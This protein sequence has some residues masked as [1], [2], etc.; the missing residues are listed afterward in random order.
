MGESST[1]GVGGDLADEDTWPWR[2]ADLLKKDL[3]GKKLEFINAALGGYSTFESFGRLWS[4][5]RFFSPDIIVVA[6]GWNEMYYFNKVDDITSWRTLPD[7]SWGFSRTMKIA[8]YKPLWIDQLFRNSQILTKIR[9]RLSKPI[10]GEAGV[11]KPLQNSYDRRGLEIFRTNLRLIKATASILGAKLFVIKQATLVVPNL[12]KEYRGWC[13][14]EYH[15]FDHDAHVDAFKQIY[16]I[17]DEEIEPDFVIDETSLSGVPEYFYDHIHP[18]VLGA[19][20]IAEIVAQKLQVHLAILRSSD[21]R[22]VV[23]PLNQAAIC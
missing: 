11:A 3:R 21:A 8:I 20:K 15:G 6:H 22:N 2:V 5:I 14:Y 9:L 7:G 18:N 13:R 17:I 1:A 16:R 4:R 19:Q 10:A 12:P 23:P